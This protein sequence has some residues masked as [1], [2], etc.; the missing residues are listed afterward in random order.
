MKS[1][2]VSVVSSV[3]LEFWIN[4]EQRARIENKERSCAGWYL[5][6]YNYNRLRYFIL[7]GGGR[8]LIFSF[9]LLKL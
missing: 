5:G 6:L 7:F 2:I 4:G 3:M 8:G 9:V 1:R